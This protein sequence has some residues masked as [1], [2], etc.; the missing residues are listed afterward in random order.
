M[1]LSLNQVQKQTQKLIMTPQMQQSIQ[2]LQMSAQELEQLATQEMVENPFLEIAEDSDVAE[3]E[4]VQTPEGEVSEAP[5]GE[6]L[7]SVIDFTYSGP[8]DNTPSVAVVEAGTAEN[9][10]DHHIGDMDLNW[11]EYYDDAE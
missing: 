1:A 3:E 9:P 4:K 5:A 8:E 11:D 10:D 6:E 2:L 7:P